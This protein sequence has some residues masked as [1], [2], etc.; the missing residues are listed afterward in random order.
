MKEFIIDRSKS[1]R[2]IETQI[3][4]MAEKFQELERYQVPTPGKDEFRE[5]ED[6]GRHPP[7][8]DDSAEVEIPPIIKYPQKKRRKKAD[9]LEVEIDLGGKY[10]LANMLRSNLEE[11]N[12]A[13][14]VLRSEFSQ[15]EDVKLYS[16]LPD[17]DDFRGYDLGIDEQLELA[18]TLI[19]RIF[20]SLPGRL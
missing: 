4:R 16:Q 3:G 10:S 7:E 6:S 14:A 2:E 20:I 8:S 9:P 19:L 15:Q 11:S 17:Y 18:A 1:S 5:F 12:E 13:N